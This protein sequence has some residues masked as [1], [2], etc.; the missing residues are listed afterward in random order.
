MGV[1][2]QAEKV[3]RWFCAWAASREIQNTYVHRS[4]HSLL[5]LVVQEDA[6]HDPELGDALSDFDIRVANDKRFNLLDVNVLA[7][8]PVSEEAAKTFLSAVADEL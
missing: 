6:Q 2:S 1:D 4:G 8:P 7:I 5:L 3:V